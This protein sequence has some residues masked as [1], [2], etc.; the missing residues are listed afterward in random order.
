MSEQDKICF[1]SCDVE[2]DNGSDRAK[3]FEGVG[4]M[5]EAL[6]IFNRFGI[7]S[8]LFVTGDVLERY[9]DTVRGWSA[10][11]EIGCHSYSHTFFNL[12]NASSVRDELERFVHI[13]KNIFGIS[14]RG[15][16]SP[17]HII[18]DSSLRA[19]SNAGFMYDSSVVPHYPMF[20]S[21]RGYMGPAPKVPYHPREFALRRRGDM[22]ILEIPVSGLF[23][24]IPLAGAWMRGLP[25]ILYR[26][27]FIF[28]K[29]NFITLSMH[30]W[31]LLDKRF[32]VKLIKILEILKNSGYAFKRGDEITN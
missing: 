16:R 4:R 3:T 5:N 12:L 23:L 20:K 1:V 32:E 22:D 9:P 21:Y 11:H 8:T 25:V 14:P 28:S 18:D 13:Y 17:S 29:P 24:G 27:L 10:D 26:L 19:V 6:N 15:F 7:S 31:D 30:S 2:H